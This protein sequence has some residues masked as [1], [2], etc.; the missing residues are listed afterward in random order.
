M[1]VAATRPLEPEALA[2][3]AGPATWCARPDRPLRTAD[4]NR[5]IAQLV[6]AL[7]ERGIDITELHV[8]KASLE[9][10]FLELTSP[11][12]NPPDPQ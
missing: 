11:E 8:Q 2:S 10:V 9:D 12:A 6:E 1:F 5:A 3:I 7:S 4:T